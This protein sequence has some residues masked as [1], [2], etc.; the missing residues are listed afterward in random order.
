MNHIQ[1]LLYRSSNIQIHIQNGF[2]TKEQRA[3][4]NPIN[5]KVN[6][7]FQY[8]T[9]VALNHEKNKKISAKNKTN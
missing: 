4:I 8:A 2:K 3:T 9:I 6:K 7:C 1:I 5:K